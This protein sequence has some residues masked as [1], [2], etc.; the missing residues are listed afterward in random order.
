MEIPIPLVEQPDKLIWFREKSGIYS[1]S[2]G[3]QALMAPRNIT[4]LDRKLLNQIRGL[5]CPAKIRILLWEF[6]RNFVPNFQNLHSRRLVA[7][8]KCPHRTGPS[9][10]TIHLAR[11]SVFASQAGS[12]L[13][14]Q[15]PS[16]ISDLDFNNWLARM[17]EHLTADKHDEIAVTI[18]ALWYARNK[19]VHEKCRRQVDEVV[20]FIKG[21]GAQYRG[22]Q[23]HLQ[24]PK[25]RAMIKWSPPSICWVKVNTDASFSSTKQIAVSG[26]IVRNEDDNLTGS[27]YRVQN[28]IGSIALAETTAIF[29]GLQF[30]LEMGFNNVILESDSK[31]QLV[32]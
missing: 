8:K 2:S 17:F 30:A 1:V 15:W 32:T 14:Y 13:S 5:H 18:W 27:G 23:T 31:L 21:F 28:Y 11:D 16:T 25:P 4:V 10:S 9:E 29:H 19:L 7:D 3:Y 20:T 26:F 6:V 22:L 24:H 12:K